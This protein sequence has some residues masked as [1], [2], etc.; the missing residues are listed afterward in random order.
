MY[1][2]IFTPR[3]I[4]TWGKLTSKEER[5]GEQNGTN[6]TPRVKGS[7][8]RVSLILTSFESWRRGL[9]VSYLFAAL[10]VVRSNPAKD[11]CM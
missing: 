5:M 10:W 2:G 7:P 1:R 3:Y 8:L 9:V 6:S 4:H 11:I